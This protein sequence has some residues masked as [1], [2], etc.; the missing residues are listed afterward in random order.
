M[1]VRVSRL[2]EC[3]FGEYNYA[4]AED[5]PGFTSVDHYID[6][7]REGSGKVI[8]EGAEQQRRR[9]GRRRIQGQGDGT[10]VGVRDRHG[11]IG[12]L[13]VWVYDEDEDADE[14]AD[15][16]EGQ[17]EVK[18]PDPASERAEH[19]AVR[20]QSLAKVGRYPATYS[21]VLLVIPQG[22]WTRLSAPP[23]GGVGGRHMGVVGAW[24]GDPP[25]GSDRL[26]THATFGQPPA[27]APEP[28][29]VSA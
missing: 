3:G 27:P 29:E 17:D 5:C 18:A 9:R 26:G 19:K 25:A 14:D 10:V 20:V 22:V 23:V 12:L 4:E 1:G 28:A 24:Q 13:L 16:D 7:L 21:A 15:E 6:W 2:Q 11:D 8:E